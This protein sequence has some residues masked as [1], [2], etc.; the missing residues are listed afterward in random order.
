MA[1]IHPIYLRCT[2]V[3]SVVHRAKNWRFLTTWRP[4]ANFSTTD[5][6]WSL[7]VVCCGHC[8]AGSTSRRAVAIFVMWQV[9]GS[10]PYFL[11]GNVPDEV[12]ADVGPRKAGDVFVYENA[13]PWSRQIIWFDIQKNLVMFG[14]GLWYVCIG[15]PINSPRFQMWK[16]NSETQISTPLRGYAH[17]ACYMFSVFHELDVRNRSDSAIWSYLDSNIRSSRPSDML[18]TFGSW[19]KEFFRQPTAIVR[20]VDISRST[21]EAWGAVSFFYL[22]RYLCT[23]SRINVGLLTLE[24][25]LKRKCAH[26]VELLASVSTWQSTFLIAVICGKFVSETPTH[27]YINAQVDP[28]KGI[29][30]IGCTPLVT[31]YNILLDTKTKSLAAAVTRSV[32]E[33][34]G[35]LPWVC[36]LAW[37]TD[38]FHVNPRKCCS[39]RP[40]CI[41]CEQSYI[42][43]LILSMLNYGL[44]Y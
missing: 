10:T 44:H 24:S 6:H 40:E 39:Y 35:G 21:S 27:K 22:Y 20:W 16:I 7:L 1:L 33:K 5:Y 11:S 15:R 29:S 17:S 18:F 8:H 13:V 38:P 31:N 28:A 26:G 2:D 4:L 32:R 19:A 23:S 34:D 3:C 14:C 9:R 12:D 25:T 36:C 42:F 30:T 43:E 37:S 41:G